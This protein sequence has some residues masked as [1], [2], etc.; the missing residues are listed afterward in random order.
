MSNISAAKSG[1]ST[2]RLDL[3]KWNLFILL[4]L[5]E[6][7]YSPGSVLLRYQLAQPTLATET[8]CPGIIGASVD[9]T[10]DVAHFF[11]LPN[12]CQSILKDISNH[13]LSMQIM[14]AKR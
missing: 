7:G 4:N 5:P 9:Q 14:A 10:K 13:D 11:R 2:L 6:V 12:L 3:R 1:T 8:H